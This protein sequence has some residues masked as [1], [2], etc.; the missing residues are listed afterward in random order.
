LL[1]PQSTESSIFFHLLKGQSSGHPQLNHPYININGTSSNALHCHPG[2]QNGDE[3]VQK[4]VAELNDA[5]KNET[6]DQP[7]KKWCG[8]SVDTGFKVDEKEDS[9]VALDALQQERLLG[10]LIEI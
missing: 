8:N 6:R 5:A 10:T 2:G 7:W 3:P 4:W 9:I 1:F